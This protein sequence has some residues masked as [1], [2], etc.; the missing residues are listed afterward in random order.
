MKRIK[1]VSCLNPVF[2]QKLGT[3]YSAGIVD[4]PRDGLELAKESIDS[5][6][7]LKKLEEL[8]QLSNG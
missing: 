8:A 1:K 7:A 6:K 3:I 2:R 4:N 5:G